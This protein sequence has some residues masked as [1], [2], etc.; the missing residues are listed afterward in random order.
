MEWY[1]GS[2][3]I[4]LY[5]LMNVSV[6][7]FTEVSFLSGHKCQGAFFFLFRKLLEKLPGLTYV[8][9]LYEN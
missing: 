4:H 1:I 9:P 3:N 7:L 8:I 6:S 2:Q 5:S